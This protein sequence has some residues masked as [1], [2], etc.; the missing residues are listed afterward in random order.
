[1]RIMTIEP[2]SVSGAGALV[3]LNLED[4]ERILIV[5]EESE[6]LAENHVN[7]HFAMI[8]GKFRLARDLVSQCQYVMEGQNP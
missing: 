5:M 1:M 8:L 7:A 6:L 4:L 3:R 2:G